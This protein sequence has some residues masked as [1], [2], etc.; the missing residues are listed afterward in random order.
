SQLLRNVNKFS[1]WNQSNLPLRVNQAGVMPLVFT[2]SVMVVL[3]SLTTFLYGQLLNIEF[4]SF[5]NYLSTTLTLGIG[6]IFYWSA[7]GVL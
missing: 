2:S 4:F 5:L 3:S 6:K 7:Y 1:L